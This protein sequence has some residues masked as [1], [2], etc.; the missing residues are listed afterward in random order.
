M[1]SDTFTS[2]ISALLR[3]MGAVT[4]PLRR[5]EGLDISSTVQRVVVAAER[6]AVAAR[7]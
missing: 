4:K 2:G 3:L 7:A 6:T 5:V 1:G